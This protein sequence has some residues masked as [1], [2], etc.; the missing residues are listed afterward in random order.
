MV[1]LSLYSNLIFQSV[2]MCVQANE[3]HAKK[4]KPRTYIYPL[5]VKSKCQI[6]ITEPI[7]QGDQLL[8]QNHP[9]T[10]FVKN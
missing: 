4:N 9:L 7:V 10:N 6:T 2:K 1:L 8:G 3:H 5:N